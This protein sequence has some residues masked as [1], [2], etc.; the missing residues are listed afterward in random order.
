VKDSN[1]TDYRSE[2][3]MGI[4]LAE[5][6]LLL[7]FVVWYGTVPTQAGPDPCQEDKKEIA[8]LRDENARLIKLS[9]DA[10]LI[11]FYQRILDSI[12][13]ELKISSS[14]WK[15]NEL[16]GLI[17]GAMIKAKEEG[18]RGK[19]ACS[20]QN[21]LVEIKTIDQHT[22]VRILQALPEV[23]GN[24]KWTAD[25]ILE[26]EEIPQFLAAVNA[27]YGSRK[28]TCAFDAKYFHRSDSD[29]VLNAE[30]FEPY[31][32]IAARKRIK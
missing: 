11:P 15:I 5:V 3:V 12:R 24:G 14:D 31:F 4:T 28:P 22:T 25:Y 21:V 23:F 32:Y 2:L 17:K 27:Y 9:K 13:V 7:V 18:A 10:A 26:K 8:R 30:Q 29:F 19:P 1:S 20:P 16:P 6:F